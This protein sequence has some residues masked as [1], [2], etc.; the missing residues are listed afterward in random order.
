M[1]LTHKI[2]KYIYI[3]KSFPKTGHFLNTFLGG[4]GTFQQT[5]HFFPNLYVLFNYVHI[6][7]SQFSVYVDVY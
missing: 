2:D 5:T 1:T 7:F 4:A 6:E 3:Y